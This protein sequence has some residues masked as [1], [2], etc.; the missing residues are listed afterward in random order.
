MAHNGGRLCGD[1]PTPHVPRA[2][3][4]LRTAETWLLHALMLI[5]KVG[6]GDMAFRLRAPPAKTPELAKA[7]A[8]LFPD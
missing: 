4:P 3:L 1:Q 6:V 8:K 2:I 5:P 7:P